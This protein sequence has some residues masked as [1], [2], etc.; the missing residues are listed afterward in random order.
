MI[1]PAEYTLIDAY[2]QAL[3]E[4]DSLHTNYWV[5]SFWAPERQLKWIH[6][7]QDQAKHGLPLAVDIV[8]RAVKMRLMP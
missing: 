1:D 4:E 7:I 6:Y 2:R 5:F 8:S 3:A